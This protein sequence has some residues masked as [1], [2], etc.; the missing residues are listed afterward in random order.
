[1]FTM[2]RILC[3][4]LLTTIAIAWA[5]AFIPAQNRGG[6]LVAYTWRPPAS[7]ETGHVV[8]EHWS[9]PGASRYACELRRSELGKI[10]NSRE[11]RRRMVE[12]RNCGG[13]GRRLAQMS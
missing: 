6:G 5:C 7:S 4:F 3:C 11:L 2:T 9:R 10:L 8:F 13:D 1:M 12:C